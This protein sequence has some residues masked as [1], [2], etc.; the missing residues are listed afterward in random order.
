MADHFL[1]NDVLSENSLSID[2]EILL[3]LEQSLLLVQKQLQAFASDSEFSQKMKLAFG[4]G[5]EVEPLHKAWLAGDFSIFPQIEIR[6]ANEIN[7]AYGAFAVATNKIYLSK[8]FIRENGDNVT[9]IASVVLEEIGHKVDFLLN[10][11]D[12]AGD[13]GNIFARL[14]R[15]EKLTEAELTALK[16]EDDSATVVVD[17]QAIK[18]EQAFEINSFYKYQ[19][20]AKSGDLLSS[21]T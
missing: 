20:I 16:Q 3:S 6:H 2:S 5:V 1:I 11:E 9:A 19:I 7:G 10:T 21:R 4:E 15:G 14:V 18:I 12:S 13:E 8:E 17:G